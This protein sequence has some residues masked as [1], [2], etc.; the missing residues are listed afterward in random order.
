MDYGIA[1]PE[2]VPKLARLRWDF[3][4]EEGETAAVSE[5]EF[6]R[7]C[8]D[9]LDRG[10][11]SGDWVYWVAREGGEIVSH[12]FINTIRPV[13]RPCNTNDRFGYITNVYTRP[14]YR[15]KGIGTELMKR[16]IKWAEDGGLE[17]MIVSPS[18]EALAF[19]K[20]A[21]FSQDT[22]FIQLRLKDY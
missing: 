1:S 6:I 16:A 22:E 2:D 9:F 10:I 12:I 19:Y 20:R 21:G 3:R 5:N 17:L 7:L 18:E 8:A 15:N 13:P 14:E 4:A 11:R